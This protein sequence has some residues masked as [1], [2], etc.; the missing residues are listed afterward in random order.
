MGDN[1][2]I[3]KKAKVGSFTITIGWS[4]A[5]NAS[6]MKRKI[7]DQIIKMLDKAKEKLID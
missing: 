6:H 4:N 5:F 1:N 3:K 2:I 7:K